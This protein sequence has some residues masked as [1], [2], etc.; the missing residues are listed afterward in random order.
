MA[1]NESPDLVPEMPESVPD[2]SAVDIELRRQ[3]VDDA[4]P[5]A[6]SWIANS[7]RMLALGRRVLEAGREPGHLEKITLAAVRTHFHTDQRPAGLSESG[8]IKMIEWNFQSISRALSMSDSIFAYVD[9]ET[10]AQNTRGYFGSEFIVP[11]Y[12]YAVSS[13]AFTADFPGLGPKCRAAVI[14]HQLA[15]FI[16][17]RIRD[18]A[19]A[20]G[21]AYR[22]LDLASA[23]FNVHC[24]PNF[25]I[26]VSPPF[27]DDRFGMTRPED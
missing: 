3:A 15:H 1:Y 27:L 14:I 7:L 21:A 10:A 26:N 11:A 22:S 24:Y 18:I 2:N 17:A 12:A 19:G 4:K 20:K 16:D 9:G 5:L 6:A 25:A 23:L 8:A 13:I